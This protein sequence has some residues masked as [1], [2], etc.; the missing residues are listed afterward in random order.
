MLLFLE[1]KAHNNRAGEKYNN[2]TLNESDGADGS[3]AC[4]VGEIKR[5]CRPFQKN[6]R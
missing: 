2:T 3:A 4:F 5:K 6:E 1:A